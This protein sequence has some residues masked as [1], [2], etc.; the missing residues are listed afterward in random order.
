MQLQHCT[1]QEIDAY[2]ERSKG[3]VVPIGSTEQH[4]PMGLIG[5]DALCPEV[6]AARMGAAEDVLVAPTISVGM[7]EHHMAF[8]GTITYRPTTLISVISDYVVSLARH[9]F[10]RVLFFN[11]HGGNIATI[12][13]AFFETYATLGERAGANAPGVRC[14]L[15]NWWANKAVQAISRELYAGAEGSHATPSEVSVTQFA[16]PGSIKHAEL[17]PKLPPDGPIYG[18]ED[19]RRR[20]PDGRMGADSSLA[21]PEHGERLIAA[22]AAALAEQFKDFMAEA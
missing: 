7:A 20:Y 22:S 4:G 16:Y 18:A 12:N 15:V 10:E 17:D 11:G 3:V 5:T 19:F 1:W 6:I 9:G 13:A 8:S 14:R 2:L 21:R